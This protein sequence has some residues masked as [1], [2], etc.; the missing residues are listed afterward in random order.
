[1][2]E[3]LNGNPCKFDGCNDFTSYSVLNAESR[4][5]FSTL[6]PQ[7]EYYSSVVSIPVA[8]MGGPRFEFSMASKHICTDY[9]YCSFPVLP[10]CDS[11]LN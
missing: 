4:A 11:T 6:R 2:T 3:D 10:G 1:V 7:T 5:E 8:Y 9:H